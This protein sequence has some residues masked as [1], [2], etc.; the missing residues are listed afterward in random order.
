MAVRDID[1]QS[2]AG[3]LRATRLV[4]WALLA[5]VLVMAGPGIGTQPAPAAAATA[6]RVRFAVIGDYG[7]AGPNALAVAN[8]VKGWSPDFIVTVGDN[9]YD[10]GAATTIDAN[11]GQYYAGYIGSYAG[12]YGPG[13][14]TN[15]FFPVLGNHDWGTGSELPYTSYFA[16]PGNE[17]YY[18]IQWGIVHLF[19]VDSDTHE[20]HG[21]SAGSTQGAWLQTQLSASTACWKLVAMHHP[22]YSSGAHGSQ[23]YMQWPYQQ[24]GADA[25]LSGHDHLY[26]RI[27]RNNFPYFVNGLGGRSQYSFATSPVAGSA[28]R[29]NAKY[30]AMLVDAY[31]SAITYSFYAAD[32]TLVDSYSQSGGCDHPATRRAGETVTASGVNARPPRRAKAPVTT[33]PAGAP[34]SR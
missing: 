26:E 34:P 14:A 1:R 20:P 5:A 31:P 3:G 7:W 28:S 24:W 13:A 27:V 6:E 25:V 4:S 17:R 19:A 18:D 33:A 29:Y 30:G 12:G 32:G 21:T 16:L 11:I 22:P 2:F 10:L 9:N 15:R 23:A 8:L